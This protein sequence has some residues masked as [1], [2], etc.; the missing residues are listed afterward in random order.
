VPEFKE[1]EGEDPMKKL[2]FE[3]FLFGVFLILRFFMSKREGWVIKAIL[4][5]AEVL[6]RNPY[7]GLF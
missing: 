3:F 1:Q 4:I 5:Y 6:A 7:S 2:Y